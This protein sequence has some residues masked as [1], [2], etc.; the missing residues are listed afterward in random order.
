[1]TV[2]FHPLANHE[3]SEAGL[4]YESRAQFPYTVVYRVGSDR[5]FVL[6]VAHSRRQPHYWT[7]RI[8]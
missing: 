1:M 6:A 8:R 4:F 7:G 2:G 5:L 3:L